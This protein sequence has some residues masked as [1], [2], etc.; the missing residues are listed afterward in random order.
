M[1]WDNF[2][3]FV[4]SLYLMLCG[5]FCRHIFFVDLFLH[6]LYLQHSVLINGLGCDVCI[7]VWDVLRWILGSHGSWNLKHFWINTNKFFM[8]IYIQLYWLNLVLLWSNST[9]QICLS[10]K[11]LSYK[12]IGLQK[13][14]QQGMQR[15]C[16]RRS[17]FLSLC[18]VWWFGINLQYLLVVQ[19]QWCPACWAPA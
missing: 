16:W 2:C 11:Y 8:K 12:H 17:N 15:L 5:L 13:Y 7:Q 18:F 9:W 14:F 4:Y 1:L 6:F 10:H 19:M 3:L